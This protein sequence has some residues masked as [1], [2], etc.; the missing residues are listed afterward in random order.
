MIGLFVNSLVLRTDLS[1]QPSFRELLGRVRQTA[2]EAY[3]HQD[4]PFDQLVGALQ[5]ERDVSHSPLFQVMF[6]YQENPLRELRTPGLAIGMLE[7]DSVAAKFDLT[8]FATETDHGLRLKLEY[9]ADLFD[10]ATIDRMLGHYRRLLEG[11]VA[12]PDRPV[13]MLPMLAEPERRK[14]SARV[15]RHPHRAREPRTGP[16]AVRAAGGADARRDRGDLRGPVAELPRVGRAL[17]PAGTPPAIAWAS[18]RRCWSGLCLERSPEMVVGLL[19]IL[20]AGG[21]YVPLDPGYPA[22]RLAFMLA[23]SGAAVL[24]T[25]EALRE[26][27]P[28][29]EAAVVRFDTDAE[30]IQRQPDTRP[31]GGAGPDHL[32]YVIYTSGSTGQPKGAMIVHRGLTNYLSWAVR[33]YEADAGQGAPVHSSFSFDLTVTSLFAPLLA[34]RRVDLLPEDRGVE[35]LAE[36]L[37]RTGRLQPGQ[38]HPGPPSAPRPA[39]RPARGRRADPGLHRRRR[40]D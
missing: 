6:S 33:A 7:I 5:L 2:M 15:E 4:L 18:V 25:R 11:A 32:A 21:A 28:A 26:R 3:A 14:L 22:D 36:A 24:L 12:D 19:G 31:E 17:E 27:L 10:A 37:R 29:H 30:A 23:D 38:A 35:A 40:S 20:K 34:G 16:P 8:L 39:A 1:G 9:D 13:T